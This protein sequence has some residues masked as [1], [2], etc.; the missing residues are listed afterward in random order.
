MGI[1][2]LADVFGN[3]SRK[4]FTFQLIDYDIIVFGL[5]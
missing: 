1:L 5:R 4:R 2:I 3:V